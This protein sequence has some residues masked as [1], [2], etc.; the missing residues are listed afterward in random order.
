[1]SVILSPELTSVI[2][3]KNDWSVVPE[4]PP[5]TL[6]E[7]RTGLEVELPPMEMVALFEAQPVRPVAE[8]AGWRMIRTSESEP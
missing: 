1:M 7:L 6:P 2:G 8:S 3:L 4:A 5:A